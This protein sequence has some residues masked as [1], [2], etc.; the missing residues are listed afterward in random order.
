MVTNR[1]LKEHRPLSVLL[2]AFLVLVVSATIASAASGP[3]SS[4]S[5]VTV[6]SPS[7]S[8][9]TVK[10]VAPGFPV[11]RVQVRCGAGARERCQRIA[12]LLR[13]P[14]GERCLQIWGGPGRA[15]VAVNGKRG[16]ISRANS[17]EIA[18]FERLRALIR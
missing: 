14:R 10:F 2:L 11:Q 3:S 4:A 9:G 7:A 6:Q 16:V 15:E 13:R 18:R 17:C 1:L 8:D 5:D 12:G